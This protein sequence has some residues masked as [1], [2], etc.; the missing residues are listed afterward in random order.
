MSE[1]L[2]ILPALISVAL[3]LG[4]CRGRT[5]AKIGREAGLSFLRLAA[6]IAIVCV[7][8]QVVLLLVVRVL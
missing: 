3:V 8:L 1:I 6:G 7:I 4:A 2:W 5:L